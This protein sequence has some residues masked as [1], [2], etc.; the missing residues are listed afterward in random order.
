MI[1]GRKGLDELPFPPV[2]GV[3]F[4]YSRLFGPTPPAAPKQQSDVERVRQREIAQELAWAQ[5]EIAQ[6]VD[7]D[8]EQA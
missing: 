5:R 3:D 2:P 1:K 8:T 4:G 6:Y 7:S